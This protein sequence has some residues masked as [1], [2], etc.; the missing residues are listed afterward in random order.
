ME[1]RELNTM[2]YSTTGI[3]WL[4][5]VGGVLSISTQIYLLPLMRNLEY[6]AQ[7][8]IPTFLIDYL[9]RPTCC[10]PMLLSITV[11]IIGM[12]LIRKGK[13]S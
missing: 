6:L 10:I 12:I 2:N 5:V 1:K 11:I 9:C 3:G 7:G 13:S 8:Q 4:S